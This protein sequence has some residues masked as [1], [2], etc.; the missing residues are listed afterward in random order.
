MRQ[1][2]H[3]RIVIDT[4]RAKCWVARPTFNGFKIVTENMT[5]YKTS[6]Y[7]NRPSYA[8]M[9]ILDLSK[10]HMYWFHYDHILKK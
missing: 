7:W 8:G 3:I 4:S 10:R 2:K 5:L 6:V 9:V 1:R